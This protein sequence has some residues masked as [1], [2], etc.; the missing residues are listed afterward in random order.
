MEIENLRLPHTLGRPKHHPHPK[1]RNP[2]PVPFPDHIRFYSEESTNLLRENREP[3]VNLAK[4][5]PFNVVVSNAIQPTSP[6]SNSVMP[7]V[8]HSSAESDYYSARQITADLSS[9]STSRAV[10]ASTSPS[11][12]PSAIPAA[13]PYYPQD[14]N[15]LSRGENEKDPT[16]TKCHMCRESGKQATAALP[17]HIM[18][19]VP[20][21]VQ[22]VSHPPARQL[23]IYTPEEASENRSQKARFPVHIVHV[24]PN[25][26]RL[27]APRPC[28]AANLNGQSCYRTWDVRQPV[29]TSASQ[30]LKTNRKVQYT[31]GYA[32][33]QSSASEGLIKVPFQYSCQSTFEGFCR[34]PGKET[35]AP[36]HRIDSMN[37]IQQE[38][39]PF[40]KSNAMIVALPRH[41]DYVAPAVCQ[42]VSA[43]GLVTSNLRYRS[44]NGHV[45][46]EPNN[47]SR[48]AN[49]AF[50]EQRKNRG[51]PYSRVNSCSAPKQQP[52]DENSA[53]DF[54][55]GGPSSWSNVSRYAS[56]N[57]T[58]GYPAILTRDQRVCDSLT[59]T[60][61]PHF[62]TSADSKPQ[63]HRKKEDCKFSEA[64]TR[65]REMLQPREDRM[66]GIDREQRTKKLEK[67]T[68]F[69]VG[70]ETRIHWDKI[71]DN[72][73]NSNRSKEHNMQIVSVSSTHS[74]RDDP[75]EMH[76]NFSQSKS[77]DVF[78][79]MR[80]ERVYYSISA[81][82]S[83]HV[84]S[85]IISREQASEPSEF[86]VDAH[87]GLTNLRGDR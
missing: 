70:I 76:A 10:H 28:Y 87:K 7:S 13:S 46:A 62:Y 30:S 86:G 65:C 8:Q 71:R 6:L 3:D 39:P 11:G 4:R 54:K 57:I 17:D 26:S 23:P 21:D 48:S 64:A 33:S 16:S 74:Q 19:A 82:P 73:E 55:Y 32:P 27:N 42:P 61:E 1:W 63:G 50:Q 36:N 34:P 69:V 83:L 31:A 85:S 29:S 41:P 45:P 59:T 43:H 58:R 66:P 51:G 25:A 68:K 72:N 78:C 9:A 49:S 75:T 44:M 20:T 38:T 40:S 5:K 14:I 56:G 15:R 67:F 60:K 24:P 18:N 80:L 35:S 53:D 12:I 47:T 2:G 77:D 79:M 37:C 52:H 81:E 84:Q 22:L